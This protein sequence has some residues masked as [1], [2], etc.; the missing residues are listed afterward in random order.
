MAYTPTEWK[1]GDV[2][3]A[4]KLNNI[5]EGIEAT[6]IKKVKIFDNSK[7]NFTSG[8]PPYG[9]LERSFSRED[10]QYGSVPGV[11]RDEFGDSQILT[12]YAKITRNGEIVPGMCYMLMDFPNISSDTYSLVFKFWDTLDE[13]GYPQ[14]CDVDVWLWLI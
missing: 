12:Y 9:T 11:Y 8:N 14:Y 3:T 6:T 5:E 13:T 2:I 7:L 4:E 1:S 10:P